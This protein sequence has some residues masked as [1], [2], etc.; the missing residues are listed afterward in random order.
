VAL[1][2]GAR[3]GISAGTVCQHQPSLD[4]SV[5]GIHV[6]A[7]YSEAYSRSTNERLLGV[8]K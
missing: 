8:L 7:K 4:R 1:V 5:S 3:R 6:T 2:T